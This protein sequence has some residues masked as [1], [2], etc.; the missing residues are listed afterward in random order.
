MLT[1]LS[2]A[3]LIDA[4]YLIRV[5][6]ALVVTHGSASAAVLAH[7]AIVHS[8]L[9]LSIRAT[10]SLF[11]SH[12]V[13]TSRAYLIPPDAHAQ[14]LRRTMTIRSKA[15]CKWIALDTKL[16]C[17]CHL[18][19]AL[20]KEA[21]LGR[22]VGVKHACFIGIVRACHRV[23]VYGATTTLRPPILHMIVEHRI[24][25]VAGKPG[26]SLCH[27]TEF[28]PANFVSHCF[29]LSNQC[30]DQYGLGYNF[31]IAHALQIF[32]TWRVVAIA[33]NRHWIL[34]FQLELL[35]WLHWLLLAYRKT[36]LCSRCLIE[37][38]FSIDILAP[39][40]KSTIFVEVI[41]WSVMY[42][43]FLAVE[44]RLPIVS[45]WVEQSRD[46][47]LG[48]EV[49]ALV[50]TLSISTQIV[51]ASRHLPWWFEFM[52]GHPVINERRNAV[53]ALPSHS[54]FAFVWQHDQTLLDLRLCS[55]CGSHL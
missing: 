30:L 17:Q 18:L 21:W 49:P 25:R 2:A 1:K 32:I 6:F 3:E 19:W 34:P 31:H 20:I 12:P 9:D 53:H 42:F 10:K 8:H 22:I 54:Q 37:L 28:L 35:D 33:L 27:R 7:D 26:G 55:A 40:F 44:E 51:S 48:H 15:I 45:V 24:D 23:K 13:L 39:G 41:C 50:L 11:S 5:K 29:P 46:M 16:L 36:I 4:F 47:S 52:L 38:W 43:V 14:Q